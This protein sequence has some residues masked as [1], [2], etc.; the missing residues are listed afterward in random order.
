MAVGFATPEPPAPKR[1]HGAAAA[2][3][4]AVAMLFA[5]GCGDGSRAAF[6]LHGS[7]I[8]NN[9]GARFT[10][11]VDFPARLESTIDA[12]LKYWGG[13]WSKL[14]DLT[15]TFDGDQHV[16]CEGSPDAVGCYDAGEIRVSTRDVSFTFYCVEETV[17]VHEIGHAVI[18]DPDHTDPRWMD[19]GSVVNDLAGRQGYTTTG[20]V[21]CTIFVDVW[22]HPPSPSN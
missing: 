12:A 15:I 5:S 8:V 1:A 6:A 21:P 11:E 13:D 3:L 10:Q 7:R 4:I 22:R 16:S 20:D 18:G 17:L 2:S 14:K 19:F 9:S